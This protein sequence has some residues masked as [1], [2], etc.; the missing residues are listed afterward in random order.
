MSTSQK[1]TNPYRVTPNLNG[2]RMR[3]KA[4]IQRLKMQ[5]ATPKHDKYGKLIH[6]DYMSKIPTAG[7]VARIE[8]NRK[9]FRKCFI[10]HQQS[11]SFLYQLMSCS[12]SVSHFLGV[13]SVSFI[14]AAPTRVVSQTDLEKF[15]TEVETARK[16]PMNVILKQSKVPMQL[17]RDSTQVSSNTH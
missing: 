5:A 14:T 3:D 8:P 1:V 15:R 2:Q 16:N 6:G 7:K 17:I 9:W 12:F 4:T 10:L 11:L 13:F